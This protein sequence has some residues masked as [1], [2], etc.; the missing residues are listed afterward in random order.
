[1][2]QICIFFA[3]N[4]KSNIHVID[5]HFLQKKTFSSPTILKK[6]IYLVIISLICF[7]Y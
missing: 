1:M 2:L 7:R 3:K 6:N 4:E 5:M